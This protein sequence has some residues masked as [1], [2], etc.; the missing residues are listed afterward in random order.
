MP[1]IIIGAAPLMEL[2]EAVFRSV[3]VDVYIQKTKMAA[4]AI[5][6]P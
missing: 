2:M 5:A 1:D 3:T 4:A 6:P